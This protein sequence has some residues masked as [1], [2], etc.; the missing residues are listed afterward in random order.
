MGAIRYS[1]EDHAFFLEVGKALRRRRRRLGWSQQFLADKIGA[2]FQNIQKY[3]CADTKPSLPTLLRL[4]KALDMPF[5]SL[6]PA[7]HQP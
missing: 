6:L 7:E 2:R 1:E 4:A 3:E 5:M